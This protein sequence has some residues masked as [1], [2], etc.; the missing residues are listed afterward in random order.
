MFWMT[1][2]LEDLSLK[3]VSEEYPVL[4]NLT[5]LF[6]PQ[7][8]YTTPINTLR[9]SGNSHHFPDDKLVFLYENINI[10]IQISLEYAPYATIDIKS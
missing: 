6:R 10:L 4:Y 9:P 3:R 5:L 7:H 2:L 1:E 8:R